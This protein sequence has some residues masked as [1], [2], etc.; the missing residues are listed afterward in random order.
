MILALAVAAKSIRNV[1]YNMNDWT[2]QTMQN[3]PKF[4]I[5]FII[6]EITAA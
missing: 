3:M 6:F 1:V 5:M 4:H 2:I